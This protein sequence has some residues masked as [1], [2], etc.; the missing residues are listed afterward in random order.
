MGSRRQSDAATAIVYRM[1]Q[2]RGKDVAAASR[3]REEERSHGIPPHW[4]NYVTVASADDTRRAGERA[5][6]QPLMDPFDVFDVGPHGRVHRSHRRRDVYLGAARAASAP[7][8]ST[9]PGASRWNELST[10]RRRPGQE[11]LRRPVRLDLDDVGTAEM[12]YTTIRNGDRMNGGIR[13]LGDQEKQMGVPPN[14]MPYF[15]TGRHRPE[16]RA[17]RGARRQRDGRPDVDPAGQQD[18]GR[19]AIRRAPCSA[20]SRARPR[21]SESA[22]LQRVHRDCQRDRDAAIDAALVI[23]RQVEDVPVADPEPALEAS[24]RCGRPAKKSKW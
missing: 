6:R 24:R 10:T 7:S 12:P 2:L 19:A 4:N 20:C 21:T 15:T 8:S 11:L 3:Q 9:I 22:R 1:F 14:W 23:A 18:R 13:P 16:R 17:G 5:W